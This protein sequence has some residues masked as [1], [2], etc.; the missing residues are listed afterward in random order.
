[1]PLPDVKM[2]NLV[3]SRMPLCLKLL[4]YCHCI[5]HYRVMC[6]AGTRVC[7]RARVRACE[8][9]AELTSYVDVELL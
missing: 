7:A 6:Y 5:A 9:Y 3:S 1:M 4:Q 2:V 8:L